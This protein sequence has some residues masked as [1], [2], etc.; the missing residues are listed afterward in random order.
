MPLSPDKEDFFNSPVGELFAPRPL[1]GFEGFPPFRPAFPPPPLDNAAPVFENTPRHI[2][3]G[4]RPAIGSP[5]KY[6]TVALREYAGTYPQ[7]VSSVATARSR[8]VRN[9]ETAPAS[10]A[11]RR[12]EREVS[13]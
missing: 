7:S 2:T 1:S 3:C 8:A 12:K 9:R 6:N 11:G 13:A 5:A 4:V 10:A